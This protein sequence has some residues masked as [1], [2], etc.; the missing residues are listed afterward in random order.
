MNFW[1]RNII[2]GSILIA[3]A[4]LLFDNQEELFFSLS[5]DTQATAEV[6]PI[7][8]ADKAVLAS[9]SS[10][11]KIKS[12]N[13]AADG[14][15]RFYANLHGDDGSSGP[16]IRNNIVYLQE[17]TGDIVK[18][19]EARRM[20]TRPLR[21]NW[22]GTNE[23]HPFRLGETLFQKLS[24]YANSEGLEVIWWLNRDFLVKDPFRINKEIIKTAYQVGKAVEGHF[25]EGIKVYFCHQQRA[26]VLIDLDIP[27]LDE[28]CILLPQKSQ[29]R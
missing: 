29:R 20:V 8:P 6:A 3:L 17:P 26:I 24:E 2:F 5:D 28:E 1:L 18:L 9:E 27:Y 14:L 22:R 16:K 11:S 23:N 7:K 19:L 4:F 25:R 15:S 10:T 13:A 12:N 21:K